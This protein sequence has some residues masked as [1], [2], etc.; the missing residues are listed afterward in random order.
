[1]RLSLQA[2][3]A[4]AK[5]ILTTTEQ[6]R[7]LLLHE[8][9]LAL[10]EREDAYQHSLGVLATE[11]QTSQNN[12]EQL[13]VEIQ[14]VFDA[15]MTSLSLENRQALDEAGADT[16]AMEGQKQQLVLLQQEVA[17]AQQASRLV[18]EY[19]L[20]VAEHYSARDSLKT[21]LTLLDEQIVTLDRQL[22]SAHQTYQQE[23]KQLKTL[24]TENDHALSSARQEV[25][26]I[27]GL[28]AQQLREVNASTEKP[29]VMPLS[30]HQLQQQINRQLDEQAQHDKLG[31]QA[32]AKI[33]NSFKQMRELGAKVSEALQSQGLD[34][35]DS[36][37]QWR[38][39]LPSLTY[40]LGE[41]LQGL[42]EL[43]FAHSPS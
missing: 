42:V 2:S 27:N 9:Q 20:W 1:L 35:L 34:D 11:Q 14:T 26:L 40:L 10:K 31:Q 39:H 3:L 28:L 18:D 7:Q 17:S 25:Q 22:R 21:E 41:Y 12:F 6:A 24:I 13:R 38:K 30:A 23:S 15:R 37:K 5:Q 32:C 29:A 16:Q 36:V 19:K 43:S 8:R 33:F 4:E